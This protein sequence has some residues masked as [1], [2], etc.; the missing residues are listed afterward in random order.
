MPVLKAVLI[1][2]GV[3]LNESCELIVRNV[4]SLTS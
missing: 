4:V 3:K 2:Q 1:K